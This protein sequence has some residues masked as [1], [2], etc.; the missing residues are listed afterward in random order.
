M[1]REIKNTLESLLESLTLEDLAK[2]QK[3]KN[4]KDRN[5]ENS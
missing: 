4:N 5:D 3:A 2:Q 1:W